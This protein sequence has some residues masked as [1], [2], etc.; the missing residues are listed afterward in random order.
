MA[1][2]RPSRE[3]RDLFGRLVINSDGEGHISLDNTLLVATMI[4]HDQD[5]E[6]SASSV[7]ELI[8]NDWIEPAGDGGWFLGEGNPLA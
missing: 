4:A 7:G 5:A 1:V 2:I 3:A 6:A 8:D